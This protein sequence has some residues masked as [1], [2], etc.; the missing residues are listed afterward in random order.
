MARKVFKENSKIY[1]KVKSTYE[2]LLLFQFN[3]CLC[4]LKNHIIP[5]SK[6][7]LFAVSTLHILTEKSTVEV[8]G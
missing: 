3:F 4:K 5:M 8:R 7:I 2:K 6:D 1:R